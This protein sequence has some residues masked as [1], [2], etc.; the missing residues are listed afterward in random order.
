MASKYQDNVTESGSDEVTERVSQQ[1]QNALNVQR[2]T[3]QDDAL[4]LC[5]PDDADDDLLEYAH[6][7]EAMPLKVRVSLLL[8]LRQ[9]RRSQILMCFSPEVQAETM[10]DLL[11]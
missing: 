11:S 2:Q 1:F 7:L 10:I 8:N 6:E 3:M 5:E 4:S 9:E